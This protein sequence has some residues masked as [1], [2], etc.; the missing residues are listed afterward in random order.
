M[1]V[2]CE[3]LADPHRFS[4]QISAAE[5]VLLWLLLLQLGAD[6][7]EPVANITFLKVIKHMGRTSLCAILPA[8]TRPKGPKYRRK[9]PG[10]RE[11]RCREKFIPGTE[12][13]RIW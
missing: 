5:L 9:R 13:F 10:P 6:H 4:H 2:P 11:L 12:G 1:Y 3:E 7:L 8:S